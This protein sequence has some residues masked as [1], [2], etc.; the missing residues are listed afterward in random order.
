MKHHYFT[1]S[2]IHGIEA[3]SPREMKEYLV[4]N[5]G[6]KRDRE[7]HARKDA[8]GLHVTQEDTDHDEKHG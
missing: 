1:Y 5:F 2:E 6:F 7:F 4:H 8:L 3:Y